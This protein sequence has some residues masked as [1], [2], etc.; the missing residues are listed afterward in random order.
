MKYFIILLASLLLLSGC[1][2]YHDPE[3]KQRETAP[4]AAE[5]PRQSVDILQDQQ[6]K[7]PA[8]SPAKINRGL[9]KEPI[10]LITTEEDDMPRLD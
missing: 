9:H 7:K 4:S 6:H 3:K 8:S 2:A 10:I 5:T 1:S